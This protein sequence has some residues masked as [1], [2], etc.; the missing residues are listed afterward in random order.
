MTRRPHSGSTVVWGTRIPSKDSNQYGI[1]KLSGRTR[2][3]KLGK[4]GADDQLPGIND[5][6]TA[7]Q[8]AKQGLVHCVFPGCGP[9]QTTVHRKGNHRDG[10]KH[11]DGAADRHKGSGPET[12]DHLNSKAAILEWILSECADQVSYSDDDT[13]N[14]KATIGATQTFIRPDAYAELHSGT[15][16]AVEFQHSP[17]DPQRILEKTSAYRRLGI[18]VWWIFSGRNPLT[19]KNAKTVRGSNNL[20]RADMNSAQINLVREGIQFFWYDHERNLIATPTIRSRVFIEPETT[21]ELWEEESPTTRERYW[22]FPFPRYKRPVLFWPEPLHECNIEVEAGD[23]LTKMV[24]KHRADAKLAHGEELQLRKSA[25]RRY[26]AHKNVELIKERAASALIV[27]NR[28]RS[29]D[30][31]RSTASPTALDR[32]ESTAERLSANPTLTAEKLFKPPVIYA[33]VKKPS[34]AQRFG[35]WVTSLFR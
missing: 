27:Q 32:S 8:L 35:D 1:L 28:W 13:E 25:E 20:Y 2:P 24:R 14:I 7:R 22:R 4:D 11:A 29:L 10:F 33:S 15:K 5:Q 6:R 26:T 16:I 34:I 31:S 3:I 21:K 30:V 18:K 9:Y 23:L 17:G 12:L 19:C